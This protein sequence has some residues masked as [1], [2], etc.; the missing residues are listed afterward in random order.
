MAMVTSPAN[1]QVK[2]AARLR[3]RRQRRRQRR[4][5][6]E[7]R[8][9]I[10]A[11]L[12]ARW[13]LETVFYCAELF[14]ERNG[15]DNKDENAVLEACAA[16]DVASTATGAAAFRKMAYRENPDGLLAVA[17]MPPTTLTGLPSPGAAPALYLVAAGLEKPGN[18]GAMLRSAAAAGATG[19]LV[20]DSV[21]DVFNPNVVRASLGALFRVPVAVAN[22]QS[23]REWLAARDVRLV[24][25]CPGAS[26]SYD[27]A[28]WRGNIAVA[29][30]SETAGLG[31]DWLESADQVAIPMAAGVDSLNAG[32]AAAV[33]LFEARRQRRAGS[34]QRKS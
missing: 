15:E 32:T 23:V 26:A 5:L 2:V 10:G 29:V 24:A 4:F 3:S 19:V 34:P 20:A 31:A 28:N 7:G 11:A 16:Q 6:V 21:V 14:A 27:G 8:R 1:P 30:G 25:A 9:E 18:L 22:G 33:L 13:P 12:E 17:A